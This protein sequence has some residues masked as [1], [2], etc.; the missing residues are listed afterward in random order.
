M[1]NDLQAV[2]AFAGVSTSQLATFMNGLRDNIAAYEPVFDSFGSIVDGRILWWNQAFEQVRRNEVLVGSTISELFLAPVPAIA[3]LVVAWDEGCSVQTS[4]IDHTFE[5]R[6]RGIEKLQGL[7]YWCRWQRIGDL[8]I[9]T[10]PDLAEH[11]KMHE[12]QTDTRSLL[13][14]ATR[15]RALA[16]ERER[17]ARGLHDTVIQSLYA[18]SLALSMSLRK[19]HHDDTKAIS[20]AIDSIADVIAEIRH[21]I[22]DIETQRSSPIRLQL[23]DILLP[24]LAASDAELDLKIDIPALPEDV[25]RHVRAVCTEATSNAVRHGHATRVE[26]TVSAAD[27]RLVVQVRDN[28]QGISPHAVL[29]NGLNNMRERAQLMGG[30][31]ELSSNDKHGTTIVWSIP[32]AGWCA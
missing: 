11:R 20:T 31:M 7:M 26:V 28:G 23:E 6:Y 19:A 8:I 4:T 29:H 17:I 24:V 30:T 1:T 21:E 15:K 13:A 5:S 22:L 18:T 3:H 32:C 16:V 25:L 14:V 2:K 9:T 10:S 12:L 27:E